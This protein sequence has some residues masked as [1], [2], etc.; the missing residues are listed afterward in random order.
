[1]T[2]ETGKREAEG[3]RMAEAA[4]RMREEIGAAATLTLMA[5]PDGRLGLLIDAPGDDG[6]PQSWMQS[7]M[8][9]GDAV[10]EVLSRTSR[11]AGSQR[12][13]RPSRKKPH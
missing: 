1:M 7:F 8:E 12:V 6:P 4:T 5:F 9:A 10:A 3:E 11:P 2:E 13:P